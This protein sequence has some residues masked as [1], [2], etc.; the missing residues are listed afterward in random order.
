MQA[1]QAAVMEALPVD[2]VTAV[3]PVWVAMLVVGIYLMVVL[4]SAHAWLWEDYL[5]LVTTL[6]AILMVDVFFVGP[7]MAFLTPSLL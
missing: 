4:T 5:M 3:P 7:V 6:V 2:L 1:L